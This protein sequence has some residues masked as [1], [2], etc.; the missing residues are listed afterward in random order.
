MRGISIP[1]YAYIIVSAS[2]FFVLYSVFLHSAG[3][4]FQQKRVLDLIEKTKCDLVI[5]ADETRSYTLI[6]IECLQ[7][8]T[9]PAHI[10]NLNTNL[11]S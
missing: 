10:E 1:V 8:N 3:K 7:K 2:I 5:L 4:D 6:N 9:N 11:N